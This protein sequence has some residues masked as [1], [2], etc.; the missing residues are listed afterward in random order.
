MQGKVKKISDSDIRSFYAGLPRKDK[1]LFS[2][3]VSLKFE[4]SSPS[5]VNTRIRNGGWRGIE[6]AILSEAIE[7]SSW[8]NG[9]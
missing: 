5:T 4:W 1:G 9:L 3:W 8:R 6:R 2:A 7:T